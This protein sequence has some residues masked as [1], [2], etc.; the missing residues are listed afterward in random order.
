MADDDDDAR[1]AVEQHGEIIAEFELIK[2]RLA[3][4]EERLRRI[5]DELARVLAT[6][7]LRPRKSRRMGGGGSRRAYRSVWGQAASRLR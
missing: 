4:I 7:E 1:Q 2:E 6:L 5:P 3:R